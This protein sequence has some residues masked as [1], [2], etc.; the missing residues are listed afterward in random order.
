[1]FKEIAESVP[2]SNDFTSAES[3]SLRASRDRSG[4]RN[5]KCKSILHIVND[6]IRLGVLRINTFPVK[7]I[8]GVASALQV[9][10]VLLGRGAVSE[11]VVEVTVALLVLSLMHA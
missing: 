9:E 10:S 6:L 11:G 3:R 7:V 1:M 2:E 5:V 8:L 4:R